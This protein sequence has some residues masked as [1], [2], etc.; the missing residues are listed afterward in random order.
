[1]DKTKY[2]L[3]NSSKKKKSTFSEFWNVVTYFTQNRNIYR[4][5]EECHSFQIKSWIS[6]YCDIHQHKKLMQIQ[7]HHLPL[8]KMI[9]IA[10]KVYTFAYPTFI[11]TYLN[12][13]FSSSTLCPSLWEVSFSVHN[14]DSDAHLL[15]SVGAWA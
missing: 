3:Q 9:F 7:Y 6:G 12:P 1:M 2:P 5:C 8:N 13:T 14:Y 10:L 11:S 4:I 15:C